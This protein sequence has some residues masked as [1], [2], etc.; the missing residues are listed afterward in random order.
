MVE[1][2]I[3]PIRGYKSVHDLI[4]KMITMPEND[5]IGYQSLTKV[6]EYEMIMVLLST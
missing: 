4:E 2:K 3:V 1:S 5:P 6:V